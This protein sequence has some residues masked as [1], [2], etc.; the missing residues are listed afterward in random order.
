[1]VNRLNIADAA[2]QI[3]RFFSRTDRIFFAAALVSLL[4]LLLA[5]PA[6]KGSI[7]SSEVHP[8]NLK[9]LGSTRVQAVEFLQILGVEEP[10]GPSAQVR[11]I[12]SEYGNHVRYHLGRHSLKQARQNTPWYTPPSYHVVV[13][14]STSDRRDNLLRMLLFDMDEVSEAA[15]QDE[16]SMNFS[17]LRYQVHLDENLSPF[18]LRAIG[19]ERFTHTD[20]NRPFLTRAL[21]KEIA[22][23]IERIHLQNDERLTTNTAAT[24]F[25]IHD[26][27]ALRIVRY[28]TSYTR[29]SEASFQ[30]EETS[31]ISSNEHRTIHKI[32]VGSEEEILGRTLR[33]DTEIDHKGF[34]R[35]FTPSWVV[36]NEET[37]GLPV[38][39]HNQSRV[40]I[41][42]ILGI[43]AFIFF[44]FRLVR[45]Q[46]DLK[47]ARNDAIVTFIAIFL[48]SLNSSF[49]EAMQQ[50]YMAPGI[51]DFIGTV[52]GAVLV[53][54]GTAILIY[55]LSSIASSLSHEIWPERLHA[56]NLF[57][58]GYLNN[59]PVGLAIM[60]GLS[61]AVL[62]PVLP[63][64]LH[65]LIPSTEIMTTNDFLF[66]SD[67]Y[68][69]GFAHLLGESVYAA[70]QLVFIT[71]LFA[72]TLV[73]KRVESPLVVGGI[74]II[75]LFWLD[76]NPAALLGYMNIP[77][78]LVAAF[79]I[80]YGFQKYGALTA[81]FIPFFTLIWWSL[82]GG[83]AMGAGP[84]ILQ[85]VVLGG[86]IT[87]AILFGLMA[88]GFGASG[89]TLPDFV[90]SYILEL[91]NRERMTRELEIARQVQQTFLPVSNPTIEGF[92]LFASCKPASEVGGDY[93]E[94]LPTGDH[95]LAVSIGD[96]SGKGIQ[97]AFFM[98]L[99]K[100]YTQSL[101]ETTPNPEAFLTRVN[102]LFY[103]NAP[104]GTFVTMI[105]GI[106]DTQKKTFNMA[107][108]GHN[109]V[110][111]YR[112]ATKEAFYLHTNGMALGM[113]NDNR[114]ADFLESQ[115]LPLETGDCILLYTDGYT[116]A[117]N[118]AGDLYGEERFKHIVERCG[119]LELSSLIEQIDADVYQFTGDIARHDDMTIMGIRVL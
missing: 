11:Q 116:E 40:I 51:W 27:D 72:L 106:L 7:F 74:G 95:K 23:N 53:G 88:V 21:G 49:S 117:M 54:A 112:S 37:S 79:I 26:D 96:V 90:P 119:N 80:V 84:D 73:R 102:S 60:R 58:Q 68:P 85:L 8:A 13:S 28:I 83:I 92:E 62:I 59:K 61:L 86:M 48:V 101:A 65:A 50:G 25:S 75:I 78:Q 81:L 22:E 43:L 33:I 39:I 98:T 100:G 107:R 42:V 24:T 18:E 93:Y 44:I 10:N 47:L 64:V 3:L 46:L 1:M 31:T 16:I 66:M 113:V 19:T 52:L 76:L 38:A 30:L 77:G 36:T 109:P 29:W 97:A 9:D 118:K 41:L 17:S 99:V 105:Y 12:R 55:I 35:S 69:L 63:V 87:S 4:I 91:A 32:S 104:R 6:Y 108:A 14:L 71:L 2:R 82:L 45:Q 57:R 94:F 70:Q 103:R 67:Q 5:L 34:I 89:T 56:L 115:T 15:S 20:L 114:F 110:L 111:V